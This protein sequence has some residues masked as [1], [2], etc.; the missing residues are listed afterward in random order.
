MTCCPSNYIVHY[1]ILFVLRS[2]NPPEAGVFAE[3]QLESI[4]G[5][6]VGPPRR[7]SWRVGSAPPLWVTRRVWLGYSSHQAR[8]ASRFFAATTLF[9]TWV[10]F[11]FHYAEQHVARSQMC[12]LRSRCE[13]PWQFLCC[14][15]RI[16]FPS[17]VIKSRESWWSTCFRS[18]HQII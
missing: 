12:V 5:R 14:H 17:I 6:V 11:L 2:S 7:G 4:D 1:V 8:V 18:S 15:C 3:N 13:F 10:L 9:P 16:F